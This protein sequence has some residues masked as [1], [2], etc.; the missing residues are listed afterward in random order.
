[1]AQTALLT[2]LQAP[3]LGIEIRPLDEQRCVITRGEAHYIV[4][5]P[6]AT[7]QVLATAWGQ[8]RD[9]LVS[10]ELARAVAPLKEF[11]RPA[12]ED[13]EP[14]PSEGGTPV[15][16]RAPVRAVLTGDPDMVE[17]LVARL[18]DDDD[19]AT[20]AFAELRTAVNM[21]FASDTLLVVAMRGPRE[22]DL[23]AV[24]RTCHDM[25]VNWLPV[26]WTRG[27][28]WTGP[29]VTPGLGA[30]YEDAAARRLAAARD[31]AVHRVVRTPSPG[32]DQGP[33]PSTVPALLDAFW[34]FPAEAHEALRDTGPSGAP[35]DV[36]HEWTM[37]EHGDATNDAAGET[38]VRR[39][40]VVLPLPTRTTQHRPHSPHD[41]IDE[42]TGV[43]LRI[44]DVV[45][46]P[47]V[48][49]DLVTRQAD[50]SD[51]RAVTAWANNILCQGSAFDDAHSA[52][53]AALGES[54]ERYCGNILDTVPIT[55]G[56][57]DELRRKHVPVLDPAEL[58]LYSE[59][60]YRAP[61]FPFVPLTR[62]LRVHWVEGRSL[63]DDRRVLVPASLVYVNW[64][65]AGFAAAA[66]T[67][68]CAFAGIAAGPSLDFAA[69]SAI[70]EIIER[71]ATMVWWLNGHPLPR[72]EPVSAPRVTAPNRAAFLHLDN[73]F[74]VPV[75]AAVV[76]DDESGL[77]NIGFSARPT[78][79]DAAAKALTEAFTL[80][81]GS[82]DLLRADGLHWKVMTDGELNGRA[83]KPWRADRRYLDDF[84]D[85]MRD[86]DD[87]MVQQQV[88][89]DPRAGVRMRH[90]LEPA[91]A[92]DGAD[93]PSL[94]SR[95]CETL[96]GALGRAGIEPI[97]ID[98]TTPDIAS[99]GLRVVRVIA[100]GTVG[101]APAA[102]P[103]LGRDR[104]RRIPVE[105]GWRET[106]L[107]E[108]EL[109]YFPLPH[110]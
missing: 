45:H 46:D 18:Q 81:E 68:F 90:L 28:L 52:T 27:R 59:A 33:A 47:R 22:S 36:L 104:V 103:F 100:P 83:F 12:I 86:C 80:Q 5:L 39:Q 23:I 55:W 9:D 77:V 82:R 10:P 26:E 60:Q 62:D 30:S 72:R 31:A 71:H 110:A 8:G 19:V 64:Y 44:R 61:G 38:I 63:V 99:A 14:P 1:M 54:V 57:Y 107:D 87:L 76:H 37:P 6:A 69:A 41:L 96:V 7:A 67:N 98:I 11:I 73:E 108:D 20:V 66:P 34:A 32:G 25:R 15:P 53:L 101:N 65:S 89:L 85:D 3:A 102:F 91:S 106:A 79:E 16:T 88:Y 42:R 70:E 109:N 51:I 56:S 50:V 93:L 40:H 43:V 17:A 74:G 84:R 48:P 75:A 95:D 58:V 49:A 94:P 35:G 78:F 13:P 105:L 29:L 4:D 92:R 24:D 97:V 21:A 2:Q